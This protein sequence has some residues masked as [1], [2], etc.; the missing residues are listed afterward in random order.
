MSEAIPTEKLQQP[1]CHSRSVAGTGTGNGAGRAKTAVSDQ[2]DDHVHEAGRR[3]KRRAM[4]SSSGPFPGYM[5]VPVNGS[6]AYH[7]AMPRLLIADDHP[8]YRLALT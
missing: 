2:L 4:E 5:L 7:A 1:S 3:R 6:P 8:L